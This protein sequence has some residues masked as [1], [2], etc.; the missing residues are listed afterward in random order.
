MQ[1]LPALIFIKAYVDKGENK[2]RISVGSE[3]Y[4]N[5]DQ[6]HQRQQ[7]YYEKA[8]HIRKCTTQ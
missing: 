8:I 2:L 3:L 4:I 5:Q 6:D 7:F 1:S